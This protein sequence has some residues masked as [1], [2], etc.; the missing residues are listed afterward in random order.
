MP[1]L[2]AESFRRPTSL[3][4]TRNPAVLYVRSY[5][6]IRTLVG[7]V[8]I[9]LP[10][11]LFAGEAVFVRGPVR[12]RDSL[13]AYYHTSMQDVFVGGLCV[14]AFLLIAYL[15]AQPW[16]WDFWLSSL[17]GVALLVVVFFPIGRSGLPPGAPRCGSAPEPAGCSPTE[18]LFGEQPVA[19]VH[20]A[21]SAVF[22]LSLAVLCFLF[23]RRVARHGRDRRMAAFEIASGVLILAAV[24]WIAAGSFAGIRIGPLTAVYSGEVACIWSFG[25]AWLAR[26]LDLRRIVL[27]GR[28]EPDVPGGRPH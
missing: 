1:R 16:T 14:V 19:Q 22:I 9:L 28:R 6:L 10:V 8:G 7:L 21:A 11:A 3:S 15:A 20:I 26:G 18:Q 25:A 13:S 17:A 12:V 23:A 5:L 27:P 4:D 24:G 2:T